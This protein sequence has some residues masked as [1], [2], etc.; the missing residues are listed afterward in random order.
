MA[1]VPLVIPSLMTGVP[2]TKAFPPAFST[3]STRM[4]ASSRIRLLH[5]LAFVQ[6]AAMVMMGLL[7]SSFVHPV[8]RRF[9]R[10]MLI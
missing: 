2:A 1:S 4:S 8:A 5:G 6:G 10:A 7:K 3:S 9:P